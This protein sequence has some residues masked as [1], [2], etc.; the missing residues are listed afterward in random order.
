MYSACVAIWAPASHKHRHPL[1]LVC[2]PRRFGRHVNT[3]LPLLV[4]QC[5]KAAEGDDE[6][7]EL[8]LQALETFVLRCPL[9]CRPHLGKADTVSL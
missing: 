8:C 2:F 7:R 1:P 6:L 3:A 9:D 5:D 4:T